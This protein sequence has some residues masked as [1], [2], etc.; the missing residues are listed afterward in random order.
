M[1]AIFNLSFLCIYRGKS[2]AVE[3]LIQARYFMLQIGA[4]FIGFKKGASAIKLLVGNQMWVCFE[5]YACIFFS[6]IDL[7]SRLRVNFGTYTGM[8]DLHLTSPKLY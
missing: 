2:H 3:R 5:L 7:P 4:A 6:G 8:Q 1:A